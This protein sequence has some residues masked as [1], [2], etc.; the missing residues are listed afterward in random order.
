MNAS[1]LMSPATF[2]CTPESYLC[3]V[4]RNMAEDGLGMLPVVKD[5]DEFRPVGVLTDRDIV[6]RAV[7]RARNPVY[8][9]VQDV[10]S[11][12]P[13][14]VGRDTSLEDCIGAMEAAG[15]RRLLVCDPNG[16]LAGVISQ[17]DL[18][19]QAPPE[20]VSDLL[21][22]ISGHAQTEPRPLRVAS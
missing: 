16:D 11:T 5:S 3:D 13:I 2:W 4:A 12:P 20:L 10:M 9:Q 19:R 7:A 17:G 1:E 18:A 6:C 21:R 15:I 14:C 8:L 22:R